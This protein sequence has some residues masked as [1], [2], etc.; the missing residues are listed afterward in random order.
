MTDIDLD[1]I[2]A[3]A[4]AAAV[5]PWWFG[6]DG[7]IWAER[8][9]DP[10]GGTNELVDAEFIAHARTDIPTL[11]SRLA[12]L[13]ADHAKLGQDYVRVM[14]ERDNLAAENARLRQR[15]DGLIKQPDLAFG[16]L[17]VIR[18][19]LAAKVDELK[20]ERDAMRPVV[21][22]AK[23]LIL[24]WRKMG[25]DES[26]THPMSPLAAAVDSLQ[27]APSAPLA[28]PLSPSQPE[29]V[30]DSTDGVGE[31][32]EAQGALRVWTSGDPEPEGVT[33]VSDHDEDRWTKGDRDA[34]TFDGRSAE[35]FELFCVTNWGGMLEM[36]GPVTEIREKI[37]GSSIHSEGG[38]GHVWQAGDF[39][40]LAMDLTDDEKAAFLAAA[41]GRTWGE[42][43]AA[44]AE[45]MEY[46]RRVA[47]TLDAA[48]AKPPTETD[49][50]ADPPWLEEAIEAAARTLFNGKNEAGIEW[51]AEGLLTAGEKHERRVIAQRVIR[52]A[53]ALIT[54]GVL[55]E[56]ADDLD[57][58]RDCLCGQC[59]VDQD[60]LCIDRIQGWLRER[61]ARQVSP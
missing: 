40:K 7:L 12:D 3:R 41:D 48:L 56:A 33:E 6:D 38:S 54:R 50:P 21:E 57:P 27:D 15:V 44:A 52:A 51:W 49:Q 19:E 36:A 39:A 17:N 4:E 46:G 25:P 16:A 60:T 11:L 30:P 45:A 22:A 14:A 55:E 24:W 58:R 5:A 47:E 29:L 9:G 2:R 37:P 32:G 10:V 20:A 1:A 34:W 26:P 42:V 31:Q 61:A 28:S 8:L 23:A 35:G 18:L 53:R 13:T 43:K 59:E